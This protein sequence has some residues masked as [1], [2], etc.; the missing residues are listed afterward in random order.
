VKTFN[1]RR[2]R[3]AAAVELA[4]TMILLV[5]LIMYT[6]FLEDLLAYKLEEQEPT[7]VAGW[8]HITPDYQNDS[9]DVGGMNRLKY[10]DHT[11]AFDSYDQAYD[12]NTDAVHHEAGTAHQCWMVSGAKQLECTNDTSLG[13][14]IL[15]AEQEFLAWHGAFNKGGMA[16][17]TATLAVMNYFLP[18]K[19][20][21]WAAHSGSQREVTGKGKL[22][23]EAAKTGSSNASVHSDA[24][25][26]EGAKSSWV[27]KEEVFAVLDDPWALNVIRD[28]SPIDSQIGHEFWDRASVYFDNGLTGFMRQANEDAK[29]Y[30]DSLDELVGANAAKDHSNPKDLCPTLIDCGDDPHS[31][32]LAWKAE[33]TREFNDGYASGWKDQR[34]SSSNRANE[35]PQHWGPP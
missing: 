21:N 12:C 9:P 8:D 33:K 34:M 7:I 4:V 3:G 24:T 1:V 5:P 16:R 13:T 10:C 6:L 26:S 29:N 2:P 14:E 19:F 28:T 30:R 17:C 25:G 20:F 15:P 31:L 27:L 11:A 32:P 22:G 23:G 18:N 35:F